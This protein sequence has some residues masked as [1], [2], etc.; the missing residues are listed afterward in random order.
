MFVIGVVMFGFVLNLL[1]KCVFWCV[2][3][4]VNL[5]CFVVFM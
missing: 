3:I 1:F 4:M 2:G 5:L